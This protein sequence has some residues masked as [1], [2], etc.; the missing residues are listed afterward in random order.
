MK[1]YHATREEIETFLQE[2]KLYAFKYQCQD[3]VHSRSLEGSIFCTFG[4]PNED[5]MQS[6]TFLES[7]GQFVFCKYFELS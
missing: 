5:L 4:Y 2:R 7:G 6:E 3:C 1:P